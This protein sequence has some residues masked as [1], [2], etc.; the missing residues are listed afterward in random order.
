MQP[1]ELSQ[2]LLPDLYALPLDPRFAGILGVDL[3]LDLDL[4]GL[5][6]R[7]DRRGTGLVTPRLREVEVQVD[8]LDAE[9]HEGDERGKGVHVQDRLRVDPRDGPIGLDSIR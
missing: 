7:T 1:P 8:R 6:I 9:E 5:L 4:L 3:D 2:P